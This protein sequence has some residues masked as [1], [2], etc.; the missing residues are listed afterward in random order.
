MSLVGKIICAHVVCHTA[1]IMGFLHA[2]TNE[3]QA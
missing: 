1:Q 2:T 3:N